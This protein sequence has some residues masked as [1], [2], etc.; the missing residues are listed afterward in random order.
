MAA[1]F[2]FNQYKTMAPSEILSFK[3]CESA[4]LPI[5]E[6]FPR[7]CKT[8]DGRTYAEEIVEKITYTNSSSNLIEVALPFPGAVVGKEFSVIG[9]ARGMWFFEASFPIQIID[10]NGNVLSTGIAQA[11]SDWMTENFVEF[12]SDIKIPESYIGPATL[13]LKRDNPSGLIQ[14]DASASFPIT[15]EY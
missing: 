10:K 4:G 3:D 12:K 7:Q 15:I 6:S 1:W 2:G 9:R 8:S 13:I 5:L 14:N 11:Q